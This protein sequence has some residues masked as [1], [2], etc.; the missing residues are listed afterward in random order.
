MQEYLPYFQ[1][2][3][4]DIFM[5]DVP[6]MGFSQGKK[7][8]DLAE[9]FQFN[10]AP[11]NYYSHLSSFISASLCAVLPNIKIMEIDV[12]QVSWKDDLVTNVPEITDGYMKTPSGIGWGTNLNED[13]LK[14]HL[15]DK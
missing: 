6:W 4:A 14:E 12:D 3:S 7:V 8:G 15:W 11:H 10:V 5:I 13:A 2:R 9:T 1:A